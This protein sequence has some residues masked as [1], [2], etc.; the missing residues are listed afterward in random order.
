MKKEKALQELI[1]AYHEMVE[2]FDRRVEKRKRELAK[3]RRD[4]IARLDDSSMIRRRHSLF[5]RF[6]YQ[7]RGEELPPTQYEEMVENI[8]NDHESRLRQ[9][10]IWRLEYRSK[11]DQLL[12][13]EQK[14]IIDTPQTSLKTERF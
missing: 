6:F 12:V 3:F 1:K 5:E 9:L 11:L 8:E 4:W 14:K 2:Q 13:A 7:F 10:E